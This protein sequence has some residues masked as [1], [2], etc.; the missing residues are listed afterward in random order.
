VSTLG[1]MGTLG[2]PDTGNAGSVAHNSADL[3]L[4]TATMLTGFN[5]TAII[6]TFEISGE[7]DSGNP[8]GDWE[9]S[10]PIPAQ[11]VHVDGREVTQDRAAQI[12][13]WFVRLPPATVIHGNNRV[14][15]DNVIYEVIGPPERLPTHVHANLLHVSG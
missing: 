1:G 2:G 13:D 4:M 6:Q 10:D 9:D 14:K 7:S 12:S 8:I 11:L 5:K 3:A 15:I